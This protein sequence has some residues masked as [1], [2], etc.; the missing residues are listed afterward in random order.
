MTHISDWKCVVFQ[1]IVKT[2]SYLLSKVFRLFGITKYITTIL[3]LWYNLSP[4][5]LTERLQ[6]SLNNIVHPFKSHIV[7]YKYVTFSNIVSIALKNNEN[8]LH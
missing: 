4:T 7:S 1:K 8:C 3:Y 6:Y 2:V 5:K